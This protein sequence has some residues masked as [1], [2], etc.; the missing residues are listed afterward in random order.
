MREA[1]IKHG[2]YM[3]TPDT[4]FYITGGTLQREAPCYVERR[5]DSELHAGLRRG[6]YCYVLTS[7]QMGKSSLM[8]RTA[9]RLREQRSAAHAAVPP[10]GAAVLET[11]LAGADRFRGVE[12]P[13]AAGGDESIA[14][15]VLDL[16]AMGHNLTA[17]QWYGGLLDRLGRQLRMEEALEAF[18]T[19]HIRL[20]PMQRWITALERVVLPELGVGRQASGLTPT[21]PPDPSPTVVSTDAS[22]LPPAACRLV[23]FIDEIDAVRSLSFSS[24]EFFAGIREC[25][26]RRTLDADFRRLT[27]CLLGV[28][29]P[30]DLIRDTRTTPFNIGRRVELDDFTAA[31]AMLLATG[32]GG[33]ATTP[34]GAEARRALLERVL[35]WTGGHPYLTQRLCQA[36]AEARYQSRTLIPA[37][38]PAVMVDRLCESLYLTPRARERDDN[39]LFVRERILRGEG[40]LASLL[41]LYARVR[42]GERV[43]DEETS[44]SATLLQLAGLLKSSG[45]ALR[46]RNR[47]YH[48]VFD[49]EWIRTHMPEVVRRTPAG[50]SAPPPAVVSAPG[51]R[52]QAARDQEAH[53][54]RQAE[55]GARRLAEGDRVG[56]LDLLEARRTAA[57]IP[58]A[59]EARATLWAWWY[60]ACPGRLGDVLGH[61]GVV[62]DA[63]FSPDGRYVAT[64]SSD[65]VARLWEPSV[66]DK[67]APP[68]AGGAH[69]A[70]RHQA[71]VTA[72]AF[73]SDGRRLASASLDGTARLWAVP[74]ALGGPAA[75]GRVLQHSVRVRAVA[76]SPDG[77]LLATGTDD[78]A[79]RLWN[80][81]TGQPVGQPLRHQGAVN[82]LAF[83][84]DGRLLATASADH[85][86]RL[87]SV[88]SGAALGQPMQ[89]QEEVSAVLFRSD[90]MLLATASLDGTARLWT[91]PTG[92]PQG[93]PMRHHGAVIALAFSL[94]GARLA[95]GGKDRTARLWSARPTASAGL[96]IGQPLA[97]AGEVNAVAFR[98]DGRVLATASADGTARTWRTEPPSELPARPLRHEGAVLAVRFH[99]HGKALATASWDG[100]ARLW[101][102]GPEI[103]PEVNAGRPDPDAAATA[104]AGVTG[105]APDSA[106]GTAGGWRLPAVPAHL[107]EMEL[108]TWLAVAARL[109]VQ[110]VA[111]VIPWQEWQ[112]LAAELC[113]LRAASAVGRPGGGG[114]R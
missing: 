3:E 13:V 34:S 94:D 51:D 36:V 104:I 16:T 54:L 18:W 102:L 12:A 67:A 24:D 107:R 64:A 33:D 45:G 112:S 74:T 39:L 60:R 79:V 87:W 97:H 2:R 31:E 93:V 26:N 103:G 90:G 76:F 83:S 82:A 89:H 50:A 58:A 71:S 91:A 68:P 78:G 10:T 70:L 98:P 4:S 11:P 110:G 52:Q 47:I 85:T 27:F 109:N 63:V 7:R 46:V 72:V 59:R 19:K 81:A 25:F 111:E 14:V 40:D 29:T 84:P 86:A 101:E 53:S 57:T 6:E 65:G 73:S 35:Y 105:P 42:G 99:P 114:Q 62:F 80:A 38:T 20:G 48:R 77:M 88:A 92:H 44:R 30:S 15:A 22:G 41:M 96:P 55:R 28:A 106:S 49:E 17:E 21:E 100:S 23:I 32:L 37:A 56:L 1:R 69:V 66:A 43:A 8:V 108:R 113:E 5:A 9:A 95:T 61:E 75:V